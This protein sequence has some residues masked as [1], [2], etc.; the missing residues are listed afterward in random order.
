MPCRVRR[1]DVP[2]NPRAR[3]IVGVEFGEISD[4][5]VTFISVCGQLEDLTLRQAEAMVSGLY[6]PAIMLDLDFRALY[7][8][9][10]YI[11]LSGM[12]PRALQRTLDKGTS[13]FEII[14]NDPELD[15]QIAGD[16]V[17]LA[18]AVHLAQT[19]VTNMEGSE[20]TGTLS[21]IPVLG[22]FGDVLA[23]VETFRDESAENRMQKHYKTLLAYERERVERMAKLVTGL[24]HQINTPL[25]IINTARDRE[26]ARCPGELHDIER[27]LGRRRDGGA[28]L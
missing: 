22:P 6:D 24:A 28:V 18:R 4:A 12:R 5:A 8:N 25:G 21:F 1:V 26:R 7:Y 17:R 20:Y 2:D 10:P 9:S 11:K 3:V 15:A 27:D 23:V 14:G 19:V 16:A 13:S